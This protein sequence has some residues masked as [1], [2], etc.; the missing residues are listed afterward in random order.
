MSSKIKRAFD[1][2]KAEDSLKE[3]TKAFIYSKTNGYQSLYR[4]KQIKFALSF[5]VMILFSGSIYMYFTPVAAISVDSDSSLELKVNRFNKVISVNEYS[6][7]G[8]VVS[9]DLNI[10]FKDYSQV[11][12]EMI[13]ETDRDST[14]AIA[15]T[16][17]CDDE[18]KNQEMLARVEQCNQVIE[19]KE[20]VHCYSGDSQLAHEAHSHG[21]ATGKYRAYLELQE[22][23]PEMEISDVEELSMRDI[24]TM[25]DSHHE[26]K[27]HHGNQ[28]IPTINNDSSINQKNEQERPSD[29]DNPPIQQEG[30]QEEMV[31]PGTPN[32]TPLSKQGNSQMENEK[33]INPEG[34]FESRG[35]PNINNGKPNKDDEIERPNVNGHHNTNTHK[36]CK[37]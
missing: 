22:Q 13:E 4:N 2:V 25:I 32:D 6:E 17:L 31:R 7:S 29:G 9:S 36:H 14:E 23:N 34:D 8:E 21:M 18:K 3:S 37:D 24:Y 15:I 1:E 26:E 11:I 16:I 12:D 5:L 30:A 28:N 33:P 27:R 10:D 35:Y 20:S 19:N